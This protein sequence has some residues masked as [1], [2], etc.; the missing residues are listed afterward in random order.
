MAKAKK[1]KGKKAK[2]KKVVTA[3]KKSAK[4][5]SKKSAKKAAKKSAK[6]SR[7]RPRRNRRRRLRRKR[8]RRPRPKKSAPKK[9]PP[10]AAAPMPEPAPAPAPSRSLLLP[11]AGPCRVRPAIRRRPM[12]TTRHP[13]ATT[14]T[15]RQAFLI[16]TGCNEAAAPW[17]PRPFARA[18]EAPELAWLNSRRRRLIH[19]AV[20]STRI[21]AGRFFGRKPPNLLLECNTLR[22]PFVELPKRPK[23]RQMPVFFASP[24]RHASKLGPG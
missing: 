15:A 23:S 20:R 7:R 18:D 10:K 5:A 6:K 4:K 2:K 16:H 17:A 19:I 24:R 13:A 21:S 1:S 12:G 9:R 14:T 11:R 8:R 22:Q 3:K